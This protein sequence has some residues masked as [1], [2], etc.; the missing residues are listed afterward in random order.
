MLAQVLYV[1]CNFVLLSNAVLLHA[2]AVLHRLGAISRSCKPY[3]GATWWG[4][5][6]EH[7]TAGCT[8]PFIVT[9]HVLRLQPLPF[10]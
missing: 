6:G 2:Q 10:C 5:L 7:G 9:A 1:T 3:Y 8:N 4:S